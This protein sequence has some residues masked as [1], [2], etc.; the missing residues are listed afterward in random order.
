MAKIIAGV[1][2]IVAAVV[3]TVLSMGIMTPLAMGLISMGVGMLAA[4]IAGLFAPTITSLA[5]VRQPLSSRRIVYGAPRI[6]GVMTYAGLSG[7]NNEYMHIVLTLSGHKM[8]SIGNMYFN[9]T[10]A[11]LNEP[12]AG[13]PG[14]PVYAGLE[15]DLGDPTNT[16][17]PFPNLALSISDWNSSCL[18]RGCA[19]A[20]IVLKYDTAR[21]PSGIPSSISFDVQ[22]RAVYDP[23]TGLTAYSNNPALCIRDFIT[24]ANFGMGVIPPQAAANYKGLYAAGTAYTVGQLVLYTD[25]YYYTC[26]QNTTGH[27]CTNTSYW[28]QTPQIIDDS[29]FI[30]AANICDEQVEIAPANVHLTSA[31]C[32][33]SW[34]YSGL[35][36]VNAMNNFAIGDLVTFSIFSGSGPTTLS[37]QTVMV[38]SATSTSFQFQFTYYDWGTPGGSGVNF[39]GGVTATAS[40]YQSRYTCNGMVEA[41]QNRGAVIT[42]LLSS[43][44]GVCI[45][46]GDAWRVYAGAYRTPTIILGP[47]DLRGTFKLDTLTTKRDLANGIKGTYVSAANNWQPS[48]FP[49]YINSTYEAQDG[50][51]KNW[52]DLNL[53]YTTDGVTAQR[54]AKIMLERI[55]RQMLLTL[56]CKLSAFPLQPGDTVMFN[57][58]VLG[59]DEA[60][61]EVQQTSISQSDSDMKPYAIG[62]DSG[63]N[64][65]GPIPV[66]GI[67]L[68]LKQTDASVYDWD[69]ATDENTLTQPQPAQLPDLKV[70]QPVTGVTVTS[71][72]GT[73]M[74]RADGLVQDRLLVSWTSPTDQFVTKGGKIEIYTSIHSAGTFSLAGAADGDDSQ[75][76]ILNVVDGTAYDVIVYAINAAG[77]TSDAVEVDNTTASGGT[78]NFGGNIST[79]PAANIAASLTI[80]PWV[81]ST[82]YTVGMNVTYNGNTYKCSTANSDA[83]WTIAHW[84]L[85]GTSSEFLGAYSAGT[86]YVRGNEVIYNSN[87]YKCILV[88]IGNAPTNST[89]WQLV[90]LQNSVYLGAYDGGTAY[91]VGNQII[92]GGV[93][94]IC[95]ANTTGNAPP[96]V[97][98]WAVIG[99]PTSDRLIGAY[100]AGTAY[101]QGNEVTYLGSY[102]IC[103]S[104]TMGNVPSTTSSYW[105]LVGTSAILLGAYAGGTSY[106]QNMECT[107]LGNVY[108]CILASMGNLPTNGTYWTLIGP[109]TT[110]ALA[111]GTNKF[112]AEHGADVTSSHT[113]ADTTLVNGVAASS[114]SPISALMPAQ[115][116]AD[117]T[118]SHTSA[119]TA[120]V[121]TVPVS[122]LIVAST[123]LFQGATWLNSN[124]AIIETTAVGGPT[125][126][127]SWAT[128]GSWTAAGG[129]PM[130]FAAN[131]ATYSLPICMTNSAPASATYGPTASGTQVSGGS[132][133]TWTIGN[134]CIVLCPGSGTSATLT[135]S[136]FGFAIP[137]GDTILG[138]TVSLS[139]YYG[140]YVGLTNTIS[141]CN[142]GLIGVA[143][144]PGS[145]WTNGFELETW[146]SSSDMWG[147]TTAQLTP[148]V[149]NNANFGFAFNIKNTGAAQG[150]FYAET[151]DITI[152]TNGGTF[153]AS[154]RIRIGTNYGTAVTLS[155]AG[156]STVPAG[157][158]VI[159][160][161]TSG[162]QDVILEAEVTSVFGGSVNA[163]VSQIVAMP[164]SGSQ[165]T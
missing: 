32:T 120:A 64:K 24:D 158:S 107:Y 63:I 13:G 128:V 7:S 144:G 137:T 92:S 79:I 14:Y 40:F 106:V 141:L 162:Q 85:V 163:I 115:A 88:T 15:T 54:L 160:S 39:P 156:S 16:S 59:F 164:Q 93:Y 38:T 70:C 132:G 159:T 72:A 153:T 4:G 3:V 95:I 68:I 123:S 100:S 136:N 50:G 55:R 117:V 110:D 81:G 57:F 94:Y 116:G 37:G 21:Y 2:L 152:H 11:L 139:R 66:L 126:A 52:Q 73:A 62:S 133:A 148:T 35:C 5:T 134:P 48:N 31:P 45:P 124:N 26:I 114:I 36:T 58:P 161:P 145:N 29:T 20:H 19:K 138:V 49:P 104:G 84:T 143:K 105:T 82:A 122:D 42:S 71:G 99:S 43:M 51:I 109:S 119:D 75:F 27:V 157:D 135:C 18:Q 125:S 108:K 61:F 76:Y 140:A 89:Y 112:A 98:Y 118:S 149:C 97:S 91:V 154:A 146:G 142:S 10:Y 6:A 25:G 17:Q 41:S 69:Y 77:V 83:S 86:A 165:F 9:G 151:F 74:V 33:K 90:S 121:N 96:N 131:V 60:I 28:T 111:E 155:G 103:I 30:A 113:S 65:V 150:Y 47:D 46:P 129:N 127:T 44:A 53:P 12:P 78:T 130:I 56:S 101:V 1:A 80:A 23:R 34:E 102:W 147:L 8:T 22:G 87:F 67:D